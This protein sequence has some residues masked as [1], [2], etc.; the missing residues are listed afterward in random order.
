VTREEWLDDQVAAWLEAG[1]NTVPAR[2]IERAVAHASA[3]PRRWRSLYGLRRNVLNHARLAEFR[4][5]PSGR[6]AFAALTAAAAVLVVAVAGVLLA[7]GATPNSMSV[8]PALPTPTAAATPTRPAP[9]PS[10]VPLAT[11][12]VEVTARLACATIAGGSS[13]GHGDVVQYR[14]VV[15]RC[16]STWSP[17]DPRVGG[18]FTTLVSVDEH[19][20]ESADIWGTSTLQNDGGSWAGAW[21]G[22]VD[23]GYT[24]HH[25]QGVFAGSGAYAGLRLRYTLTG[26]GSPTYW[27][28]GTIEA[29]AALPPDGVVAVYG[30]TCASRSAGTVSQAH[31]V[32]RIEG[33]RLACEGDPSD[34]RLAGAMSLTV[35]VTEQADESATLQGTM[36]IEGPGGGWSGPFSGTVEPGYTT[37]RINAVAVGTGGYAGLRWS[38]TLIGTAETL[39]VATG[40]ITEAP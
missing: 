35:D 32:T 4:R 15:L 33:A 39:Y 8:A 31:G 12:P 7:F 17:A 5:R 16:S 40:P 18:I 2:A 11:P 3:H 34:P 26:A 20:D 23:V 19:A 38:F 14:G 9:T 25:I 22:T 10:V 36:V 13:A 24:T 37:Q 27:L 1:P 21:R 28:T 30:H 29:S 6:S